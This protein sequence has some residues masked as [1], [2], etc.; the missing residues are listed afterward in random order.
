MSF[1]FL[2]IRKQRRRKGRRKKERKEGVGKEGE[3]RGRL[4]KKGEERRAPN[5]PPPRE[6]LRGETPG[7]ESRGYVVV[8]SWTPGPSELVLFTEKVGP[9]FQT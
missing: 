6:L 1:I 5:K 2:K 4:R 8:E 7:N 9:W 3:G